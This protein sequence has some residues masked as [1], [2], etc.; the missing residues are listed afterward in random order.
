[1]FFEGVLDF[2]AQAIEIKKI[3]ER[4]NAQIVVVDENGLKG[5]VTFSL[6]KRKTAPYIGRPVY[7]GIFYI[8]N[9]TTNPSNP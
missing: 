4:F 8:P 1:M 9:T 2:T 5:R 6:Q 3:K 7:S